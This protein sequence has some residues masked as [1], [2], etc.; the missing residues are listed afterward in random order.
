MNKPEL[1]EQHVSNAREMWTKLTGYELCEDMDC[2][3]LINGSHYH[4]DIDNLKYIPAIGRPFL[5]T[6]IKGLDDGAKAL[7][8]NQLL[9]TTSGLRVGAYIETV[10]SGNQLTDMV[11]ASIPDILEAIHNAFAGN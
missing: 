11:T 1:N 7:F 5:F 10:V 4:I 3:F 2:Y 8:N 6:I 9:T